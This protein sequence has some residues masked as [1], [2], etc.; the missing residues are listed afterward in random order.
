MRSL[1][2]SPLVLASELLEAS[3]GL[4]DTT[5]VLPPSVEEM[6]PAMVL[7]RVVGGVV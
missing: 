3:A 4:E 2:L 5:A 6:P 1:E 7:L